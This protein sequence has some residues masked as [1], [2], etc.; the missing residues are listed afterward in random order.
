[1]SRTSSIC[2][3]SRIRALLLLLLGAD[4]HQRRADRLPT[5]SSRRQ[6]R[7]AAARKILQHL[8]LVIHFSLD[9]APQV[10]LTQTAAKVARTAEFL[11]RTL[12]A[13]NTRVRD[14]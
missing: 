1:M 7:H 13:V 3:V 11:A 4:R 5:A 2:S 10:T 6:R 9:S 12:E 8:W 14:A